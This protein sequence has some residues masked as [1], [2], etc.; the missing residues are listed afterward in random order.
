MKTFTA[1]E[2]LVGGIGRRATPLHGRGPAE[3]ARNQGHTLGAAA[4]AILVHFGIKR[5]L[6]RLTRRA[7]GPATAEKTVRMSRT[8]RFIRSVAGFL[9][10][11]TAVYAIGLV[12]GVDAAGALARGLGQGLVEG[13]LRLLLLAVIA[14]SGFELAAFVINHLMETLAERAVERRRAAQLQT[15]APILRGLAQTMIVVMA[16]LMLL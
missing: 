3:H 4:G 6:Q 2:W 1:S 11:L 8:A 9:I 16:G 14:V 5:G 10:G 15:L 13:G 7:P 12:W